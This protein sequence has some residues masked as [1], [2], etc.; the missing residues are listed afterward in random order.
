MQTSTSKQAAIDRA[1]KLARIRQRCP[2]ADVANYNWPLPFSELP[3]QSQTPEEHLNELV[4]QVVKETFDADY[5][6]FRT[7]KWASKHRITQEHMEQIIVDPEEVQESATAAK[8]LVE[9]MLS[10]FIT[11]VEKGRIGSQKPSAKGIATNEPTSTPAIEPEPQ[12]AEASS[13]PNVDETSAADPKLDEEELN[14]EIGQTDRYAMDWRGLL[15]YLQSTAGSSKTAQWRNWHLLNAIAR[16][17]ERCEE[18][19]T[20]EDC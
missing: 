8:T 17:R 14:E 19:F 6:M 11:G 2:V 1:R 10:K 3:A 7:W 18:L 4:A 12:G 15:D 9:T 13:V 16:T 5:A 20:P